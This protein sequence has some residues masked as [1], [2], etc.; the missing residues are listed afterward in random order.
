MRALFV[1]DDNQEAAGTVYHF[2]SEYCRG[3]FLIATSEDVYGGD[4]ND[5]VQGSVCDYCSQLLEVS[6]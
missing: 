5:F 4:S 3:K 6:Q 2:C 1:I